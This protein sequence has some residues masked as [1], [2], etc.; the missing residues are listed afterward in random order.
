MAAEEAAE[1]GRANYKNGD[2][3]AAALCFTEALEDIDAEDT[4]KLYSNR[5]AC[6]M[7]LHDFRGAKEDAESCTALK[8]SWAKGWARLGAAQGRLGEITEAVASYE[9][10]HELDPT[11][12]EYE[13]EAAKLA[14]PPPRR[15]PPPP[16]ATVAMA[17]EPFGALDAP[18]LLVRVACLAGVVVYA[19]SFTTDASVLRLKYKSAVRWAVLSALLHAYRAHG[20]PKLSADYARRLFTDPHAQRLFGVLILLV[21]SGS[22]FGLIPVADAEVAALLA[23][24]GTRLRRNVKTRPLSLKLIAKC[25]SSFLDG[26]GRVASG[27]LRRCSLFEVTA[28]LVLLLE[29]ATPRR[30]PILVLLYW[31]YLQ[32]RCLLERATAGGAAAGPLHEAF[33]AVDARIVVVVARVP[34]L[35]KG[36]ARLTKLLA[37]QV[38]LPEKGSKPRPRCS[39]M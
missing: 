8:P 38:A 21:G 32:M 22:L 27:V 16:L 10:A 14:T 30:N 7:H 9:K 1:A 20:V 12:G 23:Q 33:F 2:Y 11:E 29:L 28:A 39:I 4:H 17:P 26:S 18:H 35:A 15:P 5:S 3:K 13:R 6:R 25:E 31:Q 34:L 24:F 37:R 19:T 36:Y